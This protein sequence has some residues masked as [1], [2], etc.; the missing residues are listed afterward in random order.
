M[1]MTFLFCKYKK[2][3]FFSHFYYEAES[4]CLVNYYVITELQCITINN[5]KL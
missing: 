5:F 2:N 3:V 4:A 1:K